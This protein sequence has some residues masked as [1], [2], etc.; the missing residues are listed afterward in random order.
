MHGLIQDLRFAA[1]TLRRSP[2]VSAVAILSIAAGICVNATVFSWIDSVLLRPLSGVEGADEMVAIKST[3]PNGELID[4]SYPDYRDF[5]DQSASFDGVI[6][7]M[8][9]P[10]YLGDPPNAERVWAQMVSGNY[11]DVLRVKPVAGR[12]FSPEEQEEKPGAYPVAVIS[13]GLWK[14]RF[15]ADPAMIGRSVRINR[16]EFTVVGVA[17][18]S[19]AGTVTGLRFDLWIPVTMHSS[20]TGSGNW[21][22]HRANRPLA[23]MGR[24]KPGIALDTARAEVRALASRLEREYP[25]DNRGVGAEVLP[26]WKS[27][28]GAQRILGLVLQIL[29]GVC[30]VVLLIVTANVSN[31]LLTKVV[32]RHREFGIR[33]SIGATRLRLARQ[34]LTESLLLSALGAACGVV[35][36]PWLTGALNV[37]LPA[38]DLPAAISPQLNWSV[39]GFTVLLTAITTVLSGLAPVLHS[40][41]QDLAGALR[42]GGRNVS[43]SAKALRLGDILVVSEIALAAIA[44]VGA[45][46]FLKSFQKARAAHPGFNA[47]HVLMAGL[48][49]TSSG[50]EREHNL[51]L[52]RQTIARLET[53]PGVKQVA[54]SEDVPLGFGGGSWVEVQVDGYLP[55]DGENMR[56]WRNLVS[57]NYFSVMGIPILEGRAF[58]DRDDDSSAHVMIVNETFVGRFLGGQ[59]AIGRTVR[60]FGHPHTIIGVVKDSKYRNLKEPP[61][62]YFYLPLAQHYHKAMA[63]A[64]EVRYE[65]GAPMPVAALRAALRQM[66][67]GMNTAII[68]PLRDY[69]SAAYF[70]QK[71]GATVLAVLAALAILLA[72]LGLY[73]VMAYAVERR[74]QEMGIRMALGAQPAQLVRAEMTRGGV[75]ALMGIAVGMAVAAGASRFAAGTLY[76]VNSTDV[77]TFAGAALCLLLATL[78][79]AYVPAR[80]ATRMDPLRAL[81]PE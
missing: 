25:N 56:L 58:T 60:A 32:A 50:Y 62:P 65:A 6:A 37:I 20:I 31:L 40:A 13:E 17:P 66:D 67:P 78:I 11:F 28:D 38:T 61:T 46:L 15:G 23:L 8:Q 52:L 49:L 45:G 39:L 69:V 44:L 79:A 26:L 19:F 36:A 81:Q 29:L 3:T 43:S 22:D 80:R 51:S 9:R 47:D 71:V 27:P 1:R 2:V 7:F 16:R 70:G 73:A 75:L 63:V 24:L 42:E 59:R 74:K 34:L 48:D 77:G 57:P 41:R 5:R 53:L 72:A 21:M 76:G 33:M 54:I 68:L 30:S 14:R 64:V 4:S 18:D 10:L 55:G 35:L 12:T